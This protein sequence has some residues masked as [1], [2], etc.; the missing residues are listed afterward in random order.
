M[1]LKYSIGNDRITVISHGT[2]TVAELEK[3]FRQIEDD[4]GFAADMSVLVLNRQ[5]RFEVSTN[6]AFHITQ[7]M[8]TL[9][10]QLAKFAIVVEKNLHYG[11]ARMI[12]A[13]YENRDLAFKVFKTRAE[14]EKWLSEETTDEEDINEA[15]DE[16]TDL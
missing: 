11:F 6:E 12:Q 10:F 2:I 13:Y 1:P 16:L 4:P 9:R 14:A 8:R 15:A 7:M 3:L 5:A